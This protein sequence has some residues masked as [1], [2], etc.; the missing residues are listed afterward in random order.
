MNLTKN[1]YILGIFF[2]SI[3]SLFTACDEADDA[4]VGGT[5]LE[6]MAGDWYV[7][8]ATDGVGS[9]SYYLISTYN[10]ASNDGTDMWIDDHNNFWWFKAKT[11]I[12]VAAMT[13]SGTDLDSSAPDGDDTYDILV[14]ISNGQ[15]SKGT[16][17]TSGG[18]SSDA[19]AFDIVFSDGGPDVYSFVGYK[20][21]GFAEDEH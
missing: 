10:T 9:G 4:N 5:N 18:N 7:Q 20:R 2:L 1:K 8:L 14:T 6:D 16:A 3:F 19:I 11:P 13:F 15:I 17:T 21:T 12:N